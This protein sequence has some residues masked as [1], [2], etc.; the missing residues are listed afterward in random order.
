M[1]GKRRLEALGLCALLFWAAAGVA[2]AAEIRAVRVEG[3]R[4][5]ERAAIEKEISLRAGQPLDRPAVSADIRRL[6]GMGYFEDV[7]ALWDESAGT[8]LFRVR[9]KPVIAAIAFSGQ[10]KLGE[11][12]LKKEMAVKEFDLFDRGKIQESVRK[13][14]DL[15]ES[16]GYYLAQISDEI[17]PGAKEGQVKLKIKIEE[18]HKVLVRQINIL[19][20]RVLDDGAIKG[21]MVTKEGNFWSIFSDRGTFQKEALEQDRYAIRQLY[22]EKGYIKAQIDLPKVYLSPDK[23]ELYLAV[24]IAEGE[25]YSIRNISLSGELIKDQAELMKEIK[26]KE[27]EIANGVTIQQ[28]I[29][30]LVKRYG[31]EGYAYANVNVHTEE[32]PGTRQIDL[33][34]EPQKG[35]LVRIERI[36]IT[37]NTQTRDKVIRREIELAEGELYNGSQLNLSR[38]NL[39]R[40]SI[41]EEVQLLT[42]RGS[43]DDLMVVEIKVKEK[44]TTGTFTLGAAFNS[45]ES[46]QVM[47]QVQKLNLFGLGYNLALTA[48]VGGK[49][50]S[51]DI[52]FQD[53]Y[54]LDK[55][56]SLTLQAFNMDRRYANFTRKST[57]GRIDTGFLLYKREKTRLRFNVGYNIENVK[58]RDFSSTLENLFDAGLTSS[59]S[60]SLSR[61]TRNNLFDPSEGSLL[62]VTTELAGGPVLRGDSSYIRHTFEGNWYWP[63]SRSRAFFIGGSVF[64]VRFFGG[65]V[66]TLF[67]DRIPLFERFF[68]GGIFSVRGFE[69]RS[70]GPYV[71]YADHSNPTQWST[72]NF[73]TGGNKAIVM[74]TE[75]IFPLFK[76]QGIKWVVFYDMGNAF[77][78]KDWITINGLRKSVGFGLRW[79]SPI[80]PLRFEWGFPLNAKE[81]DKT[82]VFDFSIGA[83]F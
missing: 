52:T 12:D 31:D 64:H 46:I 47:A 62:S 83:M 81:E 59:M 19:G 79:F 56:I 26:L 67:E 6:Y 65:Y 33:R 42:R 76:E 68:E 21:A 32:V 30:R 25:P 48:R 72:D 69:L 43:S 40:L 51:F 70:L 7:Q 14:R 13:L 50:Q 75:F 10:N 9:E 44:S 41:F 78:K 38:F 66:G 11:E 71:R 39:E 36:D 2:A 60:F 45:L 8:L 3:N 80:G 18:G 74:N 1:G 28:D 4:R 34:Y 63:L 54:F 20:N 61:D 37:G 55:N 77:D 15:Y 27:K 29:A 5:I 82:S 16:K 24:Q 58:L 22:L 23:S 49:S 57:G 17:E 53:P 73:Y 35:P